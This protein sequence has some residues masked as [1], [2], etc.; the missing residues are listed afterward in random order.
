MLPKTH[1]NLLMLVKK[2]ELLG[3]WSISIISEDI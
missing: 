3:G 1:E 2:N